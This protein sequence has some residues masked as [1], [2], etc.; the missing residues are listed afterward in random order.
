M[1]EEM[2]KAD[3]ETENLRHWEELIARILKYHPGA[4][5]SLLFNLRKFLTD[6]PSQP[7]GTPV[8]NPSNTQ[9]IPFHPLKVASILADLRMDTA[10]I[11]AGLLME[12]VNNRLVTLNRIKE[13]FGED[14]AFLLEG[15]SKISLLSS[16]NKSEFQ[17][18]DFRKMIL[19]MAKDIRVILIRL[20]LCL[21]QVR[22]IVDS[23]ITPPTR[24][25]REI[26]EIYAPIAH[27]LGIYWIKNELEDLAFR[28]SQPDRYA[29]L[30][31]Q[32]VQRRKGGEDVVRKVVQYLKKILRKHNINASVLGREKHIASIDDKL[33]RKGFSLDDLHDIIGYRIIVRKKS[34]CY[35]VLGMIHGEFHPIPGRFKDYIALPK[36]NGYQSLH[37]V[38]FGPFGNRIE[39][40]IRTE[41]MHN[42]A[43]SG[44]A[45][46]WTYKE[47]GGLHTKKKAG[48][49]GYAWLKRMLEIHR[50]TEEPAQFLENVKIDLFPDEIY[51]FTPTGDIITLPSR[52]TPVDFAYAIHSEVGDHCQGAKINGRMLPLRT[53]LNT[54]DVVE[55]I[56]GKNQKPNPD[57]LRYVVTGQAK[58]RINRWEKQRRREQSITLGRE[59]VSR[60]M[61]KFDHGHSLGDKDFRQAAQNFKITTVDELLFRVG[62]GKINPVQVVQSLFPQYVGKKRGGAKNK[63]A[64]AEWNKTDEVASKGLELSGLLPQ[65]AITVARCCSP[66]PGDAI[67]GI[68]TTGK[69]I[70][71]H[72]QGCPNLNQVLNEPE[73]WIKELD[74]PQ[75]PDR[76]FITRLQARVRNRRETVT[77]VSQAVI[78]AKGNIVKIQ[79]MDREKDPCL[80]NLEVEV[81]GVVQLETILNGV[82]GVSAVLSVDRIKG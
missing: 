39:V 10:S 20:A 68:I 6:P 3:T 18:E 41:K 81:T 16:R 67:V 34:D 54:G 57:W 63:S 29:Q 31:K 37:T 8:R 43:E 75:M 22:E 30:L 78:S 80:L 74:W 47:R 45:A 35:R 48:A 13:E 12:R 59:L 44:V 28:I 64:V 9:E 52:A 69:G 66:I 72:A 56:T 40:Q 7:G 19:A 61:H 4:D 36:S 60:E 33:R 65:M 1:A 11:A 24:L 73:R 32:V 23:G 5:Q 71:L 2:N 26:Q 77:Q 76:R 49:T 79:F 53:V 51:L 70:T 25:S 82:R 14:I 50:Q 55:V 58:Y 38:V 15:L 62:S 46:H 21:Q 42:I 17:A 27:R